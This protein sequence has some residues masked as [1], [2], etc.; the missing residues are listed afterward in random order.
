MTGKKL[1]VS[2]KTETTVEIQFEQLVLDDVISSYYFYIAEYK[3]SNMNFMPLNDSQLWHN[4]G[5]D[6][7]SMAIT[8]LKSGADYAVRI[9]PYR[10]ISHSD[11]SNQRR[12]AG[13]PSMDVTFTSGK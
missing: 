3:D 1:S 13:V 2:S 5:V 6:L 12:E 9:V 11:F 8:G 10:E 4:S 7:V